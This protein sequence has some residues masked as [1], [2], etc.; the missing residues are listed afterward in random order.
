MCLVDVS[1]SEE[2][3][4]VYNFMAW[5]FKLEFLGGGREK[6]LKVIRVR[7]TF[8][9]FLDLVLKGYRGKNVER[10]AEFFGES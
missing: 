6:G 4:V 9:L 3:W 1:N 10:V 7:G 8:V 5:N 2:W